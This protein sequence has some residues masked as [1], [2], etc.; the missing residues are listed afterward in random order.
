M[1]RVSMV[2]LSVLII[3]CYQD[4]EE[5]KVKPEK[6]IIS[7]KL[8]GKG[9]K[10]PIV[11]LVVIDRE[12]P[13]P[14][15]N[16]IQEGEKPGEQDVVGPSSPLPSEVKSEDVAGLLS[17][18]PAE[19]KSEE[20][21]LTPVLQKC[22]PVYK[23]WVSNLIGL[24]EYGEGLDW[25]W[26]LSE[27]GPSD[28]KTKE[29]SINQFDGIYKDV[30]NYKQN[31][32]HT[33]ALYFK[34][35]KS[36]PYRA[37][38]TYPYVTFAKVLDEEL[39]QPNEMNDEYIYMAFQYHRDFIYALV[40]SVN[41]LRSECSSLP[42][43]FAVGHKYNNI[44]IK[45]LKMINDMMRDVGSVFVKQLYS[46]YYLPIDSKIIPRDFV[47]SNSRKEF[48]SKVTMEELV[49]MNKRL[50]KYLTMLELVR[51]VI[52]NILECV[53]LKK[54]ISS[55]TKEDVY[56]MLNKIVNDEHVIRAVNIVKQRGIEL[57]ESYLKIF[58]K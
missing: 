55:S 24:D 51:N 1:V 41:K 7:N 5:S 4:T 57:K 23:E 35:L 39:M 58:A 46:N 14:L 19:V 27:G 50:A 52:F 9:I 16:E 8:E 29:E 26:L 10:I 45:F 28:V 25:E 33:H 18:L 2:L 49:D 13:I 37:A 54:N 20:N 17:P 32:Y 6:I 48:D 3:N 47:K 30:F 53:A 31:Y 38:D 21:A 43:K 11:P 34:K 40:F 12:I 36:R 44:V 56:Y 22:E 42:C 15:V